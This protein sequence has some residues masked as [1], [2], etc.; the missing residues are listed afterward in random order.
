MVGTWLDSS[1]RKDHRSKGKSLGFGCHKRSA[2]HVRLW[3]ASLLDMGKRRHISKRAIVKQKML[4]KNWVLIINV[5]LHPCES[6]TWTCGSTG[7]GL[8]NTV[9]WH[10]EAQSSSALRARSQR[11]AFVY[12]TRFAIGCARQCHRVQCCR[13]SSGLAR[14]LVPHEG[15]RPRALYMAQSH[16][17]C[18]CQVGGSNLR[19]GLFDLGFV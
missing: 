6:H 5:H 8:F 15:R 2:H 12:N 1:W 10:P 16:S 11:I 3:R 18:K 14:A 9:A 7:P 17:E 13:L 4:C 19:I